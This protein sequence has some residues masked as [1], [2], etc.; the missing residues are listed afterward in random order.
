EQ[1][2]ALLAAQQR[3]FGVAD[4]ILSRWDQKLFGLNAL[5]LWFENRLRL[6]ALRRISGKTDSINA[7]AQT[8][9]EKADEADDWLTI[10]RLDEVL[11]SDQD[12]SLLGVRLQ[13]GVSSAGSRSVSLSAEVDSEGDPPESVANPDES[14]TGETVTHPF[15]DETPVMTDQ[16]DRIVESLREAYSEQSEESIREVVDELLRV[17]PE[18]ATTNSDT[19]GVLNLMSM[20]V[21]TKVITDDGSIWKWANRIAAPFKENGVVLSLLA[22][23][24]NEIRLASEDPEEGRITP[25]RLEQ[26]FRKSLELEKNGPQTYARAGG[27]FLDREDVGEAEKCFARGFK[28]DRKAG[29]IALKLAGVYSMTDRPRDALH[30]LDLCLREGTEN[31][32]VAWESVMLAFQLRQFEPMLNYL[33]RYEEFVGESSPIGYYRGLANLKMDQPQL[34]LDSI[35]RERELSDAGEFHCCVVEYCALVALGQK[36]ESTRVADKCLSSPIR[37]LDYLP[38]ADITYLFEIFWETLHENEPQSDQLAALERRLLACGWMPD[39][40]FDGKRSA[41]ELVEQVRYYRLLIQ[42]KLGDDWGEHEGCHPGQEDWNNYY[43]EWG[44]LADSEE[45]AREEVL[46][47]QSLCYSGYAE[48]VDVHEE[49]QLFTDVPGIV[50][51]GAR[52]SLPDDFDLGEEADE[53]EG[54]PFDGEDEDGEY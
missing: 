5:H 52:Y 21:A 43:A 37:E 31:P 41:A 3:D 8:L 13:E 33:N 14:E 29:N 44:V 18:D 46:R 15:G 48:V 25:A 9:E 28:L 27:F 19:C 42:Q 11:G 30:V 1:N 45:R 2:Q 40:Y 4:E 12:P 7:L 20:A 49:D 36:A 38:L 54:D 16:L 50:W 32:E 22:T 10:R 51:Q 35:Q 34:A 17:T 39:A 6:L 23:V 47:I 24:G 53:G 26:L